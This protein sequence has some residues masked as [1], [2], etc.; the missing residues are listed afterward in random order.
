MNGVRSGTTHYYYPPYTVAMTAIEVRGVSFSY[1]KAPSSRKALREITFLQELSEFVVIAGASGAGKSTLCRILNGLIPTF[2]KGDFHGEVRILGESVGGRRVAQNARRVGLVFQDFEAQLFSTNVALEVAFGPEN[3]GIPR[4]EIGRR[5]R[6]A[7]SLVGLDGVEGRD[8]SRLSGGQKQR[9]A[10]ASVLSMEPDVLVLDE[11]TTDL[12]PAGKQE[13]FRLF[14]R[15]RGT[16]KALLM[17]E[18][19]TEEMSAAD[20]IVL[21]DRGCM[22]HDERAEDLLHKPNIIERYG[23]RSV[24]T[25]ALFERLGLSDGPLHPEEAASYL[26]RQGWAVQP[27]RA[28]AAD[29][30]DRTRAQGYGEPVI[31]VR[32]LVHVYEDGKEALSGVS[33]AIRRGEVLALIGQ[34]GSGKTTLAKHFNRL[35]LPTRGSVRV[36]GRDTRAWRMSEL[37]QRVGYVFQNPDHQIFADTVWEEVSFGPRNAGL[38]REE[39]E[40]RTV[41]ALHAVD[42]SGYEREDPFSLTKSERQRIAVASVL[43]TE[44][45]IL[46]LDE[47]TTGLDAP[48][49]R[50]M[51]RLV[52][53]LNQRGMTVLLIT[54]S[55]WTV[56]HYAHRCMVMK[57]GRLIADG[58]TRAIFGQEDLLRSAQLTPPGVVRLGHLLGW[59]ALSVDELAACLERSCSSTSTGVPCCMV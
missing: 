16:T 48:Q 31:E 32:D 24:G 9:L 45:E 38:L 50:S 11:P 29:M 21:M 53:R 47:P 22:V 14:D 57:E 33:F 46:I 5:V 40:R 12:D 35:L 2:T 25:T 56:T 3:F 36:F 17:V 39:V 23:L 43:A 1:T 55:M 8:P 37:G 4:E 34:N 27:E 13:V 49:Q 19:E 59:T 26:R 6:K 58:P 51:M 10:L 30:R 20:R 41:G 52:E 15:L 44:P 28:A 42:L 18:H 54:H 7:L